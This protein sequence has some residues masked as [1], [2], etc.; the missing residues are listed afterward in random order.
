MNCQALLCVAIV[1]LVSV[2]DVA[3]EGG[4]QVALGVDN[5]PGDVLLG[6]V[7]LLFSRRLDPDVDVCP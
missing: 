5:L 6:C 4:G 1:V 7:A 2:L 3:P